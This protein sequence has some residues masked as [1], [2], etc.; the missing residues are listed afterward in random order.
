MTL[1]R[2]HIVTDATL[3]RRRSHAELAALALAGG[4]DAIQFRE[5]RAWTTVRLVAQARAIAAACRAAGALAVVDDRADI[6]LAAGAGGVHLGRDD[7]DAAT[8][9]RILGAGAVIG[10]TANCYDEAMAVA[11]TAVDYLGVGPV[12]GTRSKANPAPRLG[13]DTLARIAAATPKPIIA[14]G[15]IQAEHIAEVLAAGAHGVAVLSAVVAAHAPREAAAACRAAIDA[16]GGLG[17]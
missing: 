2:L 3:Q 13:L 1:P 7:L 17:G 10:G 8:A 6:A 11:D 15:G 9:R 16:H 12:Y 14:I 5:K 4:A